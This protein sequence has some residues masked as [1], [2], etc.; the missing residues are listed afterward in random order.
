MDEAVADVLQKNSLTAC[1]V[2]AD[3]MTIGMKERIEEKA[4]SIQWAHTRGVVEELRMIKDKTEIDEIRVAVK[5]AEEAF[6]N[7]TRDLL[8]NM[9][10]KQ[11]SDSLEMHIRNAGGKGTSF[12]PIVAVGARAALPHGRASLEKIGTHGLLLIDWG[13]TAAQYHSDLTRVIITGK[14]SPKLERI[15]QVVLKAQLAAIKAIRPGVATGDV[16]QVARKIIDDAGFGKY[17]GHGLGHGIGMNVHELPRV[18]PAMKQELQPGM[19][20]TVEP[21]I[22][23]PGI[24]GVRI[25]DD[26]L[27][28]KSGYEVLSSLPKTLDE[29]RIS[30]AS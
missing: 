30:W 27:V 24:G 8:P 2:E 5:Y 3:A 25:E 1:G 21:G 20:I 16:D 29:A 9:T 28:T 4:K 17:Y 12:V 23:L 19:M 10:E 6:T 14:I 26:V 15:Y 13:A 7:T 11:V 22:Y 18:A